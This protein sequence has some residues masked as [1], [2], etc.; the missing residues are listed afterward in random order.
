[1]T[2]GSR[3][4][5]FRPSLQEGKHLERLQGSRV[6]QPIIS[7]LIPNWNGERLLPQCLG[8]IAKW[9]GGVSFEIIVFDNGSADGSVRLLRQWDALLPISIIRSPTN[10]GFAAANNLAWAESR[11]KYCLL[12]NND[13]VLGGPL[14]SVADF[15]DNHPK[16]AICQGPLLSS[17][18]KL[19]DSIGSLMTKTG[20]LVHPMLG[21]RADN[22][23]DSSEIFSAKGAAM[24]VRSSV[25]REIGLFD[26]TSFAYFEE[27]DLCWRARVAGW[28]V[29]YSRQLPPAFH[30]G[31]ATSTIL[32][33][34]QSEFHS[35]KNRLR[36][37]LKNASATTLFTM[38]PLHL[39]IC[40]LAAAGGALRRRPSAIVNIARAVLWNLFKA[41]DTVAARRRVQALRGIPD[42]DVFYGVMVPMRLSDLIRLGKMYER[43]KKDRLSTSVVLKSLA[44]ER[45]VREQSPMQSASVEPR[46]SDP[47]VDR[48]K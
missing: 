1:M 38:L 43:G 45:P 39:A 13:A 35:Y 6:E 15:F 16:V 27:T 29:M 24:Y 33:P 47:R 5:R 20:F 11:G 48:L 2:L 31:G 19:I 18:G 28:N 8:G 37:I 30:V 25:I 34:S 42:N 17:D 4:K 22:N 32:H 3:L 44:Q 21:C 12:L 36:S 9:S 26:E 23:I 41:G 40:A 10:I 7:I 14:G 46:S